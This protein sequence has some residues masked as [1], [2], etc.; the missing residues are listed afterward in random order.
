MGEI[1][2]EFGD[3]LITGV[4]FERRRSRRTNVKLKVILFSQKTTFRTSCVNLSLGG[5][6]LEEAP[7][8][9]FNYSDLIVILQNQDESENIVMKGTFVDS[10]QTHLMFSS[11][12]RLDRSKLESWVDD[13]FYQEKKAA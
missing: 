4:K 10:N 5:I 7:P 8:L 3:R 6:C 12:S 2:S 9:N 1:E 11:M 13:Y